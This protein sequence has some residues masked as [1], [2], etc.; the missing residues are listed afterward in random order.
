MK[1]DNHSE[2]VCRVCE[3]RPG[4]HLEN[5]RSRYVK[6]YPVCD[7]CAAD[8]DYVERGC[9]PLDRTHYVRKTPLAH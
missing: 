7:Q 8:M 9:S 5:G 2:V 1:S 6:P 4:A 3:S